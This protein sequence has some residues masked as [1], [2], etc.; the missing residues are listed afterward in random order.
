MQV[1]PA[2]YV[3]VIHFS[4]ERYCGRL[5][6]DTISGTPILQVTIFNTA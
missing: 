1:K 6:S 5:R 2:L 3:G 4:N